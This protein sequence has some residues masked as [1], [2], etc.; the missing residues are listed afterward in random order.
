MALNRLA[1]SMPSRR[2]LAFA[3]VE[4]VD[5]SGA[6]AWVALA[7]FFRGAQPAFLE[8]ERTKTELEA[9]MPE[10]ANT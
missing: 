7:A 2:A 6:N 9:L 10:D 8:H 4:V 5:V 3:A 1:C